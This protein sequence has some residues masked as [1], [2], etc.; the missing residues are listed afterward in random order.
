MVKV[1]QMHEQEISIL[2]GMRLTDQKVD[3]ELSIE[4]KD[5]FTD[6]VKLQQYLWRLKEE[7]GAPNDKVTASIFIKRYAFLP[8][9]YLYAMTVWNKALNIEIN[10]V[11]IES[12]KTGGL[13][14]PS[15][16]FK[17]LSFSEHNSLNREDWRR[18]SIKELFRMHL[19]PLLN[20]MVH[21]SKTSKYI[22]WENIAVY[23]FWLYESVLVDIEDEIVK[24][25]AYDDFQ[26]IVKEAD[27]K[28]FGD[29]HQNPLT[30]YYTKTAVVDHNSS[31]IRVRT[32]C[33]FSN[34][35]EK[36]PKSCNIC[37]VTCHKFN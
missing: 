37:P 19:F 21:V 8:V 30:K 25:R 23:I 18:S 27:G 11:S 32:T 35:L 1:V 26:F 4:L 29:Y 7:F 2:K 10:N 33:C 14:L 5:L 6:D 34:Q 9:I 17:N 13:W 20:R 12:D 31:E 15:F 24:Q 22:L 36:N 16:Y 28:L 3:S